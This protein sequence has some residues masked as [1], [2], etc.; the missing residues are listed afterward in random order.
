MCI[1]NTHIKRK[2]NLIYIHPPGLVCIYILIYI[3]PSGQTWQRQGS[4]VVATDIYLSIYPYIDVSI[5][6]YL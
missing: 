6:V 3:H 4:R 5:F 1:L 2:K